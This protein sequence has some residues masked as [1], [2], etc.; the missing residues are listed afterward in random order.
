MAF[1]PGASTGTTNGATDV[2]VVSAPAASTQRIIGVITVYNA[3]TA[4]ATVTIKRNENGTDRII[5]SDALVSGDT[6]HFAYPYVLAATT[7]SIEIVLG[8][9]VATTELDWTASYADLS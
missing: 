5:Y 2:T 8:G 7:S 1:S 6:I 3:D 4:S 9:A